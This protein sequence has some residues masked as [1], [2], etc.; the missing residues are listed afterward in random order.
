MRK[1]SS[2]MAT[3]I[4]RSRIRHMGIPP[5]R[6]HRSQITARLTMSSGRVFVQGFEPTETLVR[7]LLLLSPML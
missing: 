7:K 2:P 3:A 1:A 4:V 5:D 6:G